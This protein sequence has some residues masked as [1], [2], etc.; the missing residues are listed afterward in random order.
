MYQE[1]PENCI[2]LGYC[3]TSSGNTLQAHQDN[4]SLPSSA[5]LLEFLTLADGTDRLSQ[6]MGKELPLLAAE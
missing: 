4:L 5:V 6:N 1:V 2:L 3:A